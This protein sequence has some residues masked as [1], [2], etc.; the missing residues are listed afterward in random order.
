MSDSITRANLDKR[1]ARKMFKDEF[2]N[3]ITKI[4]ESLHRTPKDIENIN[5][6]ITVCVRKRPL[7]DY[8]I[9]KNAFDMVSCIDPFVY[10]HDCRMHAV[11]LKLFLGYEA[12]VY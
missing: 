3:E 12:Y 9:K 11:F 10:V 5:E 6:T 4:R 8:E 2:S 7:F 1:S